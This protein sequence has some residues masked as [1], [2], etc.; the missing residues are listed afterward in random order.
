MLSGRG[1]GTAALDAALVDDHQLAGLDVAHIFR[2]DN[3]EPAGLRGQDPGLAQLAQHQR[4]HAQGIA[5]ADQR[6]VGQRHEG[7]GALHLM[8]RV[9]HPI[10]HRAGQAGCDQMDDDLSIGGRL[11]QRAALL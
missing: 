1:E 8:Q 11:E 10:D 6:I 7:I 4:A 5:H 9:D 3:V 2:A